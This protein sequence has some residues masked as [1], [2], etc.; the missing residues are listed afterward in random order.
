[1]W[2]K[3]RRALALFPTVVLS[4]VDTDGYPVSVRISPEPLDGAG[5]LRF[6]PPAD[7]EP[8][9]GPASVLGHSHNEQTWNLKA[10]L[11]RGL[12]EQDGAGWAFRPLTFIP[13]SGVGSPLDQ[14]KP[15]LRLRPTAKRYLKRRHLSRPEIPWDTIK[16]SY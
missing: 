7:L 1:M 12:L 10:F 11:A 14:L 16:R 15:L 13:G 2:N 5:V 6:T 3:L 4:W 9:A 8:R